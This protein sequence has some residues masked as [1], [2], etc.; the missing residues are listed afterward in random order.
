[1]NRLDYYDILPAG[2]DAYLSNHGH[3]F[4]KAM[5]EWA[6]SMMEDRHGNAIKVTDR[7]RFEELLRA[8]NVTIK[9]NEG[10]YDGPYVYAMG[11]ADYLGSSIIDDQHLVMFVRDYIDDIDGNPT[12]P[13]DEFLANCNAKG[14]DIPWEDLI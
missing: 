6:V 1:M 13:F 12:R 9:R 10:Y 11:Q 8:Y 5:L 3:H 14:V 2:M 7:K 4:S